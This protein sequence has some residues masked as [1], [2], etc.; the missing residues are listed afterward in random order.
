M[1]SSGTILLAEEFHYIIFPQNIRLNQ[2]SYNLSS[3]TVF[4]IKSLI[5]NEVKSIAGGNDE[6]HIARVYESDSSC[7]CDDELWRF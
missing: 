1:A 3:Q 5:Y 4:E 7:S 6:S 2:T